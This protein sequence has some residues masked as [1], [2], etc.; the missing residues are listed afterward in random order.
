MSADEPKMAEASLTLR[1]W[2]LYTKVWHYRR[3]PAQM[4]LAYGA[5]M[6]RLAMVSV[7]LLVMVTGCGEVVVFGH[8]VREA[9]SKTDA[10]AGAAT[11][12]GPSGASVQAALGSRAHVVQA[13]TLTLSPDAKAGNAS[14]ASDALLDAI[15]TE[16]RSR[17]LLDEHNPQATGTAEIVIDN[18]TTRPTVNAVVFGYQMMAGTLTGDVRVNGASGEELPTSHIIAETRLSVAADGSDKNPLAPLYRR[19]A[20]LTADKLAGVV[21]KPNEPAADG[22]HQ[23]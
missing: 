6:I 12:E 11:P 5:F 13:V 10:S 14:I 18:A 17:K 7:L 2:E 20:V 4:P 8:V 3:G 22:V 9:P 15:R 23:N 21:S 19:F 1:G 16:L